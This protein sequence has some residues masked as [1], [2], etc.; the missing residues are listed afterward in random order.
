MRMTPQE[1]YKLHRA[2]LFRGSV[3]PEAYRTR[4]PV[5][6]GFRRLGGPRSRM[7]DAAGTGVSPGWEN[8]EFR[9]GRAR[10]A[11]ERWTRAEPVRPVRPVRTK[12]PM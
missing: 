6:T 9:R 2:A 8:A 12:D 4:T 3:P 5:G 10:G 11:A 1:E 7:P